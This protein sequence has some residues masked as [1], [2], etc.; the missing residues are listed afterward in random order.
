MIE[1]Y[2]RRRLEQRVQITT[3]EGKVAE[4]ARQAEHGP[5]GVSGVAADVECRRS[6]KA[7]GGQSVLRG[8]VPGPG[9]GLFRPHYMT[10]SEQEKIEAAAPDYLRN[11][12]RIITETGLRVYKELAPM[13]KEDVDLA[14]AVVWIPDSKTA[15]GVAEVPLTELAVEAFR[16]QISISGPGPYLFPNP[17]NPPAI[18]PA[19]RRSGRRRFGRREFLTSGFTISDRRMRLA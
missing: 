8:G 16:K 3:S 10:W 17:D 14:N 15:S 13:K 11:V 1:T 9:E 6:Q 5:S 12:I 7:A 18:R 2:L 19:S 4:G